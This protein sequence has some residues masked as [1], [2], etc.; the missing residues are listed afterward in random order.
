M[1]GR[2]RW[3]IHDVEGRVMVS[4]VLDAGQEPD[5]PAWVTHGISADWVEVVLV[6]P[7]PTSAAPDWHALAVR[8]EAALRSG[9][10]VAEVQEDYR[11]ASE[12]QHSLDE[13]IRAQESTDFLPSSQRPADVSVRWA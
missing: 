2:Y 6:V 5:W 7:P 8:L 12:A 4:T 3:S 11:I 13:R 1:A 9:N 10:G